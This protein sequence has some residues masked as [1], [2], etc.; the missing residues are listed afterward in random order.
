MKR[1]F[2]LL[3][4]YISL[5]FP[6]EARTELASQMKIHAYIDG[7]KAEDRIK[8]IES[9]RGLTLLQIAEGKGKAMVSTMCT[10]KALTDPIAGHLLVN[11]INEAAK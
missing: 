6:C 7:G 1:L 5:C 8:R 2:I 4:A 3:L 11:I 9:M 10:E